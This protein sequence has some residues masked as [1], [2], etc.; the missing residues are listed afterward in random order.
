MG[1]IYLGY[2]NGYI[3]SYRIVDKTEKFSEI[4]FSLD[5][6]HRLFKDGLIGND[7]EFYLFSVDGKETVAVICGP[8]TYYRIYNTNPFNGVKFIDLER[9]KMTKIE[10]LKQKCRKVD[11]NAKEAKLIFFMDKS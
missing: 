8:V 2:R 5:L 11:Y 1:S 7:E 10:Q 6:S 9:K 4:L 3:F